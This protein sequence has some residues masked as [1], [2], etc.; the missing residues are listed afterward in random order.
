[1]DGVQVFERVGRAGHVSYL[2][3]NFPLYAGNVEEH[4][5][6]DDQNTHCIFRGNAEEIAVPS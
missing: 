3:V 2:P 1:M 5:H 4:I 6:P